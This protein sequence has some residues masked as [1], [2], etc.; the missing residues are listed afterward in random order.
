[1]EEGAMPRTAKLFRHGRSQAV[2]LLSDFR[3][4]GTEVYI[5]RAP[6]TGDVI[7][8]ARPESRDGFYKL[9]SEARVPDEFLSDRRDEAP[10]KRGL[11]GYGC[12]R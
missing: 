11:F 5:R 2:R 4:E 7:L 12:T 3:F 8:P 9:G 1:M 10:Q 6:K